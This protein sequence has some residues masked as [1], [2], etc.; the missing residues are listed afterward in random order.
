MAH[1]RYG[2]LI[3]RNRNRCVFHPRYRPLARSLSCC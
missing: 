3:Y 1:V 2:A